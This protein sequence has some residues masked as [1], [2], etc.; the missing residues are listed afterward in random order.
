MSKKKATQTD[1]STCVELSGRLTIMRAAELHRML[2]ERLAQ[3]GTIVVDGAQVE[4]ID[5]SILQLLV[6][7]WRT[8]SERGIECSWQGASDV[9]KKTAARIGV[10]EYLHFP[11]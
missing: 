5:T 7:L 2:V 9:L 4:E 10:A 8:S 3:G 11:N 6:S 1:K